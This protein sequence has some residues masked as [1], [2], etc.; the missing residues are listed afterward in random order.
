MIIKNYSKKKILSL[1]IIL[2]L[3]YLLI[4]MLGSVYFASVPDVSTNETVKE[5]DERV[6]LVESGDEAW[7]IRREMITQAQSSLD[8]ATFSFQ[9]GE[10]VELFNGL[11]LD[12]ADRGVSIRLLL[13]GVFHGIRLADR[14]IYEVFLEH[15]NIEVGMY[16]SLDPLK[17]WT[18]NNRMHDKIMIADNR[19]GLIGGRNIGDKYFDETVKGASHDREI[20]IMGD[21]SLPGTLVSDMS[22]YMDELWTLPYVTEREK[23][24]LALMRD[25]RIERTSKALSERVESY[26]ANSIII[27][28]ADYWIGKSHPIDEGLFVRNGLERVKKEPVVWKTLLNQWN[29]TEESFLL[30]SPYIIFDSYMR[31]SSKPISLDPNKLTLLTNGIQATPNYLAHSGY[32]NNREDLLDSNIHVG[33]YQAKNSSLHMKSFVR[34][35]K[36][37]GVGSYNLD[38]RSTYLSTESMLIVKSDDLA[39][40]IVLETENRYGDKIEIAD[41]EQEEQA[42][43]EVSWLKR[44]TIESLRPFTFLFRRLL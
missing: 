10:S 35:D 6:A 23:S 33:E 16:E 11:L 18:F 28:D 19:V 20:V 38:P 43:Q 2:Y 4:G 29:Q 44:V 21:R 15:E 22:D 27:K 26:H 24:R 17:P 39:S 9:G 34:D 13:D 40:E 14:S 30:K 3:I 12:A 32:R 5:T 41:A 37:V 31:Q 1:V 25:R 36:W 42:A 7:H 8:I